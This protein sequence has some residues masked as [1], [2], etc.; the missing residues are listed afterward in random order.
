MFRL[1][2]RQ[3]RTLHIS[4][5]MAEDRKNDGKGRKN[6]THDVQG[7]EMTFDSVWKHQ[8]KTV[9]V[10]GAVCRYMN[11]KLIILETIILYL[12]QHL[13][14]RLLFRILD[15]HRK[16]INDK[17]SA[18]HSSA[19]LAIAAAAASREAPV[20]HRGPLIQILS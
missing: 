17:K 6:S 7:K 20:K 11:V 14:I 1:L 4:S 18:L 9:N 3:V 10:N 12:S 2:S 15:F 19:T 16:Q 13:Y 8:R 5:F